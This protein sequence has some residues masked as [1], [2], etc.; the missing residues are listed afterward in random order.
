MGREAALSGRSVRDIVLEWGL[1]TE[2]EVDDVLSP[3]NLMR[4]RF[5]GTYYREDPVVFAPTADDATSDDGAPASA[6]ADDAET[7]GG[8]LEEEAGTRD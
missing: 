8:E 4:P 1:L 6:D 2:D 5:R 3:E 7:E